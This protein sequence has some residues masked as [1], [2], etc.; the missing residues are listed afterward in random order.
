VTNGGAMRVLLLVL[1]FPLAAA[2]SSLSPKLTPSANI[3]EQSSADVAG[4]WTGTW[5][6]TG[7]YNSTREDTVRVDLVQQGDRGLGRLVMEGAI[8]AES[9]PETVRFQGLNGIR[10]VVE[11][12]K[13]HV[14]LRHQLDG[15]LFTADMKLSDDGERM[16]GWVRDSQ[17][18]VGLVLTRRPAPA[19]P[20]PPQQAAMAAPQAVEPPAKAEPQVV[21]LV[22]EQAERQATAGPAERPRQEDYLATQELPAIQFDY[23]KAVIRPD[24]AD[25]LV[26][27][28]E[29]LK[30]HGDTVVLV[31]GHCDERGTAEYNVAL[32]DRR[33]KAAKDY[34]A[35]YGVA[36][37]RIT[38]VSHGKE[39][40]ACTA[41]TTECHE[42][43]RRTEFRIK[44]R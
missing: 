37:D 27:H 25:T 19:A 24:S 35:A 4:R 2:C 16:F 9:V 12:S 42:M 20:A 7:I 14:K 40:L 10:I 23:D 8:A 44:S 39:R 33:A 41:N 17:P 28:A 34:L 43:N 22:P 30:E 1:M 29:W 6:G 15:R 26:S 3:L 21:A 31:E 38:T 5:T 18:A 32:G 13:E 36:P 11:V